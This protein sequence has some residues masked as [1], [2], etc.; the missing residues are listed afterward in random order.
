MS[1]ENKSVCVVDGKGNIS[2]GSERFPASKCNPLG[3]EPPKPK[4][5]TNL[6][7]D[8]FEL[9]KKHLQNIKSDSFEQAKK[10]IQDKLENLKTVQQPQIIQQPKIIIPQVIIES[11]SIMEPPQPT[12]QI[13]TEPPK[14][15]EPPPPP[16]NNTVE[17]L[18]PPPMEKRIKISQH[19]R[20]IE[21]LKMQTPQKVEIIQS[22]I[23]SM[24]VTIGE[25]EEE[26]SQ[27]TH[28]SLEIKETA[29]IAKRLTKGMYYFCKAE[30][31]EIWIKIR[32][33][34]SKFF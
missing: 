3:I 29:V 26:E 17:A 20:P 25:K 31:Y 13:I 22:S 5:Y 34:C 1:D 18:P 11:P 23:M 2:C 21:R 30:A 15:V 4:G 9:A 12:P 32:E 14:I 7:L 33:R 10:E 16:Q 6:F 24:S 28:I 27:W 8:S 19:S